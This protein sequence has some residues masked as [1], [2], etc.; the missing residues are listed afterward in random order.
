MTAEPVTA[1]FD[2]ALAVADAILYEGYLLYPYRR[3][4]A[5]NRV[6]WQFGVLTPRAW[7][8][9]RGVDDE[10]VAGSAEGWWQQ[11]ECLLEASDEATVWCRVRFLQL[12]S[13]SV[14]ERSPEGGHRTVDRLR[15]G[16]RLELAFDEAIPRDFD[17]R[18]VVGEALN[19]E[20]RFALGAPGGE[21]FEALTDDA[22]RPVGR[23]VSRSWPVDAAV[24]V[25]AVRCPTAPRLVRLRVRVENTDR[26]TPPDA[27]RG[28][29][30]RRS[31]IAAHTLAAACDA[32]FVSLLDPPGWAEAEARACSNIRT[33]PVLAGRP[34]ERDLLLSSPI[35]LY[36]H[37]A[38]A[39][40]SPGDLHD[41]TEIDEILSLRTLTLTDAEKREARATD[42]RAAAIL[43]RVDAMPPEVMSRLHGAVRSLGPASATA[44]E[45]AS[46][47]SR[48][49]PPDAA[50]LPPDADV[51]VVAGRVSPRA[52][53]C[54]CCRSG[55]A[56]TRRTCSW[57][58][59][60]PGWRPCSSTWTAPVSWP[61]PWRTIPGPS[62]TDGTGGSVTSPPPR[63]NHSPTPEA[64]NERAR[65]PGAR[66]GHRQRV[67]RR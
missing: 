46:P 4:S 60:P 30:L 65:P 33:F 24:A 1:A 51:V 59:G 25:S 56:P 57:R 41:G 26:T 63:S 45:D 20:R 3:S 54:A 19:G 67:P 53:G 11:T 29:A 38:I 66:G 6:R 35:L 49:T 21:D 43:D 16:D 13:R 48:W 44:G 32:S 40:E 27:P 47:P 17:A 55:G 23:T 5:K 18:I 61:S 15:I 58:A 62:S 28:E 22:G 34:G 8:E 50:D 14:E 2:R 36:D 12:R 39:P 10:G 52:A 42:P 31:L 37:P 9:A 7:T 64:P